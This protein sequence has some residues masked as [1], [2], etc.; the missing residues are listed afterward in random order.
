[1][2]PHA[3][4]TAEPNVVR[5]ETDRQR[6]HLLHRI[7][8]M[9][10]RPMTVL[11]VIWLLLLVVDMT[12]GL[13]PFLE[14]V[15]LT[16]WGAFIVQFALELAIAPNKLAY[17]RHNWITALA[18]LLPALRVLRVLRAFRLLRAARVARS[19]RLL[20]LFTSLNRG[21]R[22]IQRGFARQGFGYVLALTLLVN[23][24]A[25]AG[26]YAFENP[27]ALRQAG[28]SGDTRALSSYGEAVWWTA[29]MLTTMGSEYWPKTTEGRALC[30]LLAIY[31]FAIFGYIT[32]S[33]AAWIIGADKAAATAG[34]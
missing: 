25:A 31:S 21:M 5:R 11:S 10:D 20:R 17:L 15:N 33:V 28:H 14:R 3:A 16:I 7:S 1:M 4:A 12:Q 30:L 23:F 27:A 34:R 29:M 24:A 19:V 32:A 8:R 6:R 26:M 9:L 22:T 2:P 13:S 18:L